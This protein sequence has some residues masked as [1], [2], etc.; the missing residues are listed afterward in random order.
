MLIGGYDQALAADGKWFRFDQGTDNAFSVKIRPL[1]TFELLLDEKV[2]WE[3]MKLS[4]FFRS[5]VGK[6]RKQIVD[7]EG[8]LKPDG[9][10]LDY[11]PD[12]I[13]DGNLY[14]LAHSLITPANATDELDKDGNLKD[15]KIMFQFWFKKTL[16]NPASFAEGE[17]SKG[18]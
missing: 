9:S 18:F 12:T 5:I 16:D 10:T 1:K 11:N 17:A 3:K 4:E 14:E 13:T 7:W 6:M 15:K 8:I 2:Q